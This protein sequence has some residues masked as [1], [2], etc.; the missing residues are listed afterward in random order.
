MFVLRDTFQRVGWLWFSSGVAIFA[1][2][3]V[4]GGVAAGEAGKRLIIC[5]WKSEMLVSGLWLFAEF[6][7]SHRQIL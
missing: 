3:G 7:Q 5:F 1:A 6:Q 4:G 2:E